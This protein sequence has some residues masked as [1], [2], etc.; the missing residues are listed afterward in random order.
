M[1]PNPQEALPLPPQPN[2][3][4]YKRIAKDLLKACKSG[5]PRAVQK[6]AE[7]WV[8]SLVKLSALTITPWLPVM[9]ERWIAE[10]DQFAC[11][12]LLG[13]EGD[14]GKCALTGAQFV[15]ARSHGF[16]SWPK[17]TKHIKAIARNNSSV[18]RFETAADAIVG[19][20]LETLKRLLR[21]EPE[22]VRARS[23]RE[24]GATL[25]HYVSANGVEGYRQKT[26]KN[27]VEI[28]ELL[29][30]AD[31]EI[32]ATADVYGGGWTAL[33]LTATSA[34]PAREGVQ[35]A[36]LRTLLDHGARLDLPLTAGKPSLIHSCLANGQPKAAEF[37]AGC[38][39]PV[40]LVEAAGLG[41]LDLVKSY[42]DESGAPQPYVNRQGIE[43]AYFCSCWCGQPEAAEFLL[44]R[45]IDPGLENADA[46]NGL[47]CAAYG[48]HVDT[49]K[50]LLQHGSPVDVRDKAF[51]ATPLDVALW[52]WDNASDVAVRE[53]CYELVALLARA[54]AKLDPQQ[55]RNPDSDS[56]PMLEKI[57]SDGRMLAA[58]RGEMQA[59]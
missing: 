57:E 58:L 17:F 42:F 24:H 5:E 36:L 50:V 14:S 52:R 40:D 6:W 11:G 45:G 35:I 9:I 39:A 38:G 3:E 37:L 29:L 53:R 49:V 31:A 34:H 48:A 8:E 22:L 32:D 10:V 26:P 43:S 28:T 30:S 25:L 4:Q 21:E 19:G 23:N 12:K 33:G 56:S 27:I 20:D 13:G 2:I 47:H 55:W 44:E 1:S 59:K 15:I 7:E 41:R 54:G 46:R 18:S 16:E 51:R